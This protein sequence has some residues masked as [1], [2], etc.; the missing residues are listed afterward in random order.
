VVPFQA[1]SPF[2]AFLGLIATAFDIHDVPA[3]A[4]AAVILFLIARIHL[5]EELLGLISD[6]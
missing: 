5:L 2:Q 4:A 6:H 3:E 1:L